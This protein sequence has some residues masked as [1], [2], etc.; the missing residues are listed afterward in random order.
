M[1]VVLTEIL[2]QIFTIQ[3]LV[4]IRK[5][6]RQLATSNRMFHCII[7]IKEYSI[8]SEETLFRFLLVYIFRPQK[9]ADNIEGISMTMTRNV[10]D[11]GRNFCT[12]AGCLPIGFG[13]KSYTSTCYHFSNTTFA[14]SI[15]TR[16]SIGTLCSFPSAVVVKETSLIL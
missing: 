5:L 13:V 3:F 11:F 6:R 15:S 8:M 7:S 1:F 9:L 4:R 2:P 10:I 14:L 16:S 12:I